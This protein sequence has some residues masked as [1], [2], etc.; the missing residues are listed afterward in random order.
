VSDRAAAHPA[1]RAGWRAVASRLALG[2]GLYVVLDV[3]W[4]AAGADRA[5]DAAVLQLGARL[6][7]SVAH[8]PVGSTTARPLVLHNQGHACVLIVAMA[9]VS[10]RLAWRA[11]LGRFGALLALVATSHVL[12][13]ALQLHLAT[14]LKF[15]A[16]T[17]VALLLPW[18]TA[19]HKRVFQLLF[20]AGLQIAPFVALAL[21]AMWNHER[22][23]A[24]PS[25]AGL[26]GH[27]PRR[28]LRP[29]A[30]AGLVRAS[31]SRWGPGGRGIPGTSRRTWHSPTCS[32]TSSAWRRPPSSTGRPSGPARSTSACGS[33][34]RA[35]SGCRAST[36]SPT[37]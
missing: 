14:A 31:R 16:R 32:P 11:R 22:A 19:L 12:A 36:P 10:S 27:R 9:V 26:P 2:L 7:S 28:W 15:E 34:W 5:Y 8:F 18:E 24:A 23:P 37:A 21:T 17:G 35:S 25:G 30:A 33:S 13:M 3:A 4:L 20:L 29:I 6:S 1:P